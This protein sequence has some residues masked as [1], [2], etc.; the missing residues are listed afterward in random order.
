MAAEPHRQ[1]T[2]IGFWK[3]HAA[4][5]VLLLFDARDGTEADWPA[6]AIAT[7]DPH[8]AVGHDGLLVV[9]RTDETPARFSQRMLNPDGSEDFCGNG[10]RCTAAFLYD[11]GEV[12]LEPLV[13]ATMA[14]PRRVQLLSSDGRTTLVRTE[15]GRADLH[16]RTDLAERADLAPWVRRAFLVGIGTPHLVLLASDEPPEAQ[17]QVTSADLEAN[18]NSAE[19][20][21]VTWLFQETRHR[22]RM[23]TW[24]RAVGETL[25]CGTGAASA[26]VAGIAAGDLDARATI[27]SRGGELTTE[28]DGS[29]V[30]WLTGP[31]E[32]V[33]TGTWPGR[34]ACAAAQPEG[35]NP[36]VPSPASRR[37]Q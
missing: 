33:C 17:W 31:V 28:Q 30:L 25:S 14:G 4:G 1:P 32:R 13:L 8:R 18:A 15:L 9:G 5:N 11:H 34:D 35:G 2:A 23:R 21:S 6:L 19:R 27:V 29:D 36:S 10:L 16:E 24:E 22:A 26:L 7:A 12:A 37:G 20:V 3:M